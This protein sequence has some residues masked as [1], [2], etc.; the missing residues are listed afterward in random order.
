MFFPALFDV[1]LFN[2]NPFQGGREGNFVDSFVFIARLTG[3]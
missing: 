3:L 1:S 2:F